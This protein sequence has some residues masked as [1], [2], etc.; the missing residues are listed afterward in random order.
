MNETRSEP[1]WARIATEVLAPGYTVAASVLT[2]GLL[3]A[4]PAQAWWQVPLLVLLAAGAPYLFI[5]GLARQGIWESRHVRPRL[6][7]LVALMGLIVIECMAIT[8]MLLVGAPPLMLQ[9]LAACLAGVVALTLVTPLV[10][11]SIHV[12]V[13]S[14]TAG[15]A[16]NFYWPAAAAL[17]ALGL[18]VGAARIGVKDHTPLE[19]AT[20]LIVGF[21]GGLAATMLL[22]P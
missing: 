16:A 1:R 13:L 19:V 3:S 5:H 11:A 18:L 12:G 2:I 22:V 6:Q 9:L 20:G 4:T 10:R 15:I 8:V 14:V 21:C 17:L 7:R